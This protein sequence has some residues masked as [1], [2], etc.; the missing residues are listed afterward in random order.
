MRGLYILLM[1]GQK[2]DFK[3]FLITLPFEIFKSR[4]VKLALE[5]VNCIRHSDFGKFFKLLRVRCGFLY[6]CIMYKVCRSDRRLF[7][8]QEYALIPS[9]PSFCA[10]LYQHVPQMRKNALKIMSKVYGRV[11]NEYP[12]ERL[13]HL[14]CFND[15]SEALNTLKYYKVPHN[16]RNKIV[17]FEYSKFDDAKQKFRVAK[18]S[19]VENKSNFTRLFICR[20]GSKNDMVKGTSVSEDAQVADMEKS[21]ADSL[22]KQQQ[23]ILQKEKESERMGIK[24]GKVSK[25]LTL[26]FVSKYFVLGVLIFLL[27]L[28]TRVVILARTN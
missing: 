14:L 8:K 20:G 22:L 1:F 11:A 27:R 15:E 13:V 9:L 24:E 5:V 28:C 10:F 19:V 26:L 4:D 18:M 16:P 25:V 21:L 17:H 3:N 6:S 7:S 2:T 23:M 12:L